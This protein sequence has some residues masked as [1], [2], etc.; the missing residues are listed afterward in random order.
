MIPAIMMCSCRSDEQMLDVGSDTRLLAINMEIAGSETGKSRAQRTDIDDQWSY[1]GFDINDAMGFYASG[2]NRSNNDGP[3]DNFK[4]VYTLTDYGKRFLDSNGSV[5]SP[6]AMKAD[7]VFMYYPY[8]EN[9][10]TTG[11]VLRDEVAPGD[12]RCI[13]MLSASSLVLQGSNNP[14]AS[15]ETALYGS[16][17]HA[18]SELIIMRGEGFDNPPENCERITVVISN[19]CTN[20]T[21]NYEASADSWNC[22]PSLVYDPA[23]A[24]GLSQAQAKQWNA[25]KG[26]NY[27]ITTEDEVGE[28]A[29]YVVLP[30]IGTSG[31]G[32]SSVEYIELYDNEG[33]LQRV[34]SL[35][36]SGATTNNPTK[37]LDS[38][39]RYPLKINM[40]ELVPTVNPYPILPWEENVDLTDSRERG[41][42]N[43]AEFQKW[44]SDYNAYLA[45]PGNPE[46]T[47]ALLAYG[48]QIIDGNTGDTSWHF[49]VFNDLDLTNYIP[50]PGSDGSEEEQITNFNI[51]VP[52]LKDV[53]DGKSTT[54]SNGRFLNSKITGLSKTFI[55]NLSGMLQNFDFENPTIINSEESTDPAGILALNMISA[56]VINCNIENGTLFNPGG[57]SGMVAGT[58]SG[59]SNTI[60]DCEINGFI[61]FGSTVMTPEAAKYLVGT[62]E[63]PDT[64]VFDGNNV[65]VVSQ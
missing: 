62:L 18:F 43:L 50:L 21:V 53:L 10:N 60:K 7:E 26:G 39:W 12:I 23:N 17:H 1:V 11:M 52:Q 19:P 34:S 13:D 37:F 29:W 41:I 40:T 31:T 42:N 64:Q 6:S 14:N 30:T 2:G 48:D 27:G 36:L 15:G 63:S 38:G 5:F 56:S 22:Y 61:I 4:L 59:L 33:N 24:M 46:K 20:I 65:D 58:M 9:M 44:V 47:A 3:F 57:P 32:R 51:I 45:E 55:G 54:L 35:K 16:F 49:Y 28:E 8:A 25:W